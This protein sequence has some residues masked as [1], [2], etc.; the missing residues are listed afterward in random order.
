LAE[1]IRKVVVVVLGDVSLRRRKAPR[2]GNGA[3][4]DFFDAWLPLALD[5]GIHRS[6]NQ[7]GHRRMLASRLPA[8]GVELLFVEL[9]LCSYH[10]VDAI[11]QDTVIAVYPSCI[12]SGKLSNSATT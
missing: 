11:M 8:Q 12:R 7:F 5:P 2:N 4:A 6:A 10:R 9:D 1:G 3:P